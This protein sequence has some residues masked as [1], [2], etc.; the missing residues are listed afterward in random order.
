MFCRLFLVGVVGVGGLV[1]YNYWSDHGGPLP[2]RAVVFE[3]TAT[4]QAAKLANRATDEASYAANKLGLRMS[5]SALTA[6]I[7]SKM[8]LDDGV[9]ARA[10][11]VDTSGSIVTLTGVVA[12]ASERERALGLARETQGVTRVV[13]RLRIR[14]KA[15]D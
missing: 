7:K 11:D 12:S 10:I 5:D 3:E 1:A 4:R 2:S 9:E 15:V 8:A 13:D 14:K 6:K